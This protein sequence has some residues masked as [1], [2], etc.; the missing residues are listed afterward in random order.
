MEELQPLPVVVGTAGHIDHGKSALVEALTGTHPDRWQEERERGITLDLGYAELRFADGL[1]I[2]FVDVPGHEKLVRKM[3]AGAT[4]MGAAMLVVACDD[5]VMPQTREHFEVLQLLGVRHGLVVLSKADLAD[6]ETR[7]LVA[8]EVADL[9]AGTAW[10]EVPVVAASAHSGE[11]LE[12]LRTRLREVALAARRAEDPRLAFRLPVQ[13]AFVLHGAGTVVTGVCAAGRLQEGEQVVVLPVGAGSRVRRIQVHGRQAAAAR[14]GLRTALNLPEVE[15]ALCHRGSVVAAPGS[16]A[17]GRLLRSLALPLAGAPRLRHGMPVQVLA[18]TAAV[19]ARLW[20]P[21]EAR[22]G[23]GKAE[24]PAGG[25]LCELELDEPLVLAAGDRLLL[26]RPSPGRNLAHGRF[27]AWGRRRLRRRDRRER[28]ALLALERAL[29]GPEEDLVAAVL[30]LLPGG[31]GTPAAVAVHLGWRA[32]AAREALEEAARNGRVRAAGGGRFVGLGRAGQVGRAVAA[33]VARWRERHPQR[34]RIPL[35]GLRSTLGRDQARLLEEL[36]DAD[37]EALG[38]RRRPGT[39]WELVGAEPPP[40]VAALAERVAGCLAAKGLVPPSLAELVAE[41]GVVDSELGAALELL[42]D[43]GR[44][45]RPAAELVFAR[46]AVEELRAAVVAQLQG[47]G[48]DIPGL[49]DSFATTR[50]YLMPLL[51]YLD[52]RGVTRRAG[53]NRV[54]KDPD[55]ALV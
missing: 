41:L 39:E 36:G 47:G 52:Q 32:E 38:L 42:Q 6:A 28:E 22:E 9:L 10:Q 48:M 34:L 13:R 51:E 31:A 43:Q 29:N 18:H 26:R 8:A 4:G 30:E 46:A 12:E 21:P 15:P 11:G 50:K 20:L 5:G 44:V 7:E 45:V 37:L 25:W 16:L 14:P 33:A 55:A 49:R 2:G 3:V 40:A 24:P 17:T 35:A 27:L 23:G 19:P 1:E 53:P 54:L